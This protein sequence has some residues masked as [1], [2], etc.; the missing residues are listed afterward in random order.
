MSSYTFVDFC[1][2]DKSLISLIDFCTSDSR[3]LD[4]PGT[5]GTFKV[6]ELLEK[7]HDFKTEVINEMI[8]DGLDPNKDSIPDYVSWSSKFNLCDRFGDKF[9]YSEFTK[10]LLGDAIDFYSDEIT[11]AVFSIDRCKKE[12]KLMKKIQYTTAEAVEKCYEIVYENLNSIDYW[13]KEIKG[14]KQKLRLFKW[15]K[16]WY[17]LAKILP[18]C[19]LLYY[20]D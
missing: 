3:E 9:Y 8:K 5:V 19:H 15:V 1:Y 16:F 17:Y 6:K 11:S 20:R 13:K 7:N 14:L 18:N 4:L 12:V 2:K 10:N